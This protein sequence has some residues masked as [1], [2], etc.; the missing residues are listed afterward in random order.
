M[1]KTPRGDLRPFGTFPQVFHVDADFSNASHRINGQ[2]LR[3]RDVKKS[4]SVPLT[5][6]GFRLSVG[7]I[8]RGRD[9]ETA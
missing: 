4:G 9:D 6:A 7:Q 3:V 8:W 5:R 2:R 1:R